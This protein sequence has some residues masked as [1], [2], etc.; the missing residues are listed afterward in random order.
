[1]EARPDRLLP[2]RRACEGAEPICL[3]RA[4]LLPSP[5][6]VRIREVGG[7]AVYVEGAQY[8]R[9]GHAEFVIDVAGGSA[10]GL[11]LEGLHEHHFVTRAPEP[12]GQFR[13]WRA[14]KLP[15]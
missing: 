11:C 9:W 4:E 3:T 1:M 14:K 13:R 5:D 15:V 10:R 12:I 2:S 6:D 8:E 7:A